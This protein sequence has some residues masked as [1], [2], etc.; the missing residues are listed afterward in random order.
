MSRLREAVRVVAD[1]LL[2]GF[3]A[4]AVGLLLCAIAPLAIGWRPSV[5]VSGSMTP[6]LHVGDVVVVAP[7]N[8]RNVKPR[9]IIRF[10]DPAQPTRAVMHRIVTANTDGTFISRGDAND[11]ADSTPV[12]AKNILGVARI[13]VPYLGLPAVMINSG[14]AGRAGIALLA[15]AACLT[16]ICGNKSRTAKHRAARR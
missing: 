3:T 1:S 8:P 10:T 4:A 7:T 14:I 15:L 16:A 2:I 12:P 13:R 6:Q 9:Q 11:H 5:I